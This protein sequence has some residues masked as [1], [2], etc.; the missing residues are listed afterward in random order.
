M[1]QSR[2]WVRAP[3]LRSSSSTDSAGLPQGR[4]YVVTL[5]EGQWTPAPWINVVANPEFGFLA[6][7]DGS[8]S[9]WSLN[10]QQNQLTPWSNDPVSDA[11]AEA[12][13]IRD[14]DTGD[15]WTAT[16]LPI[17]EP[18]SAYV[19]RHGFGYSRFEHASHGI[20]LDLLQFVPLEGSIKISRL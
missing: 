4:E 12:I 1:R 3:R 18:S 8:G 2:T 11:P 20:E 7:A 9:T 17:R 16:P 19:V 13:Y 5:G 10:A 6:S 14:G 15:L